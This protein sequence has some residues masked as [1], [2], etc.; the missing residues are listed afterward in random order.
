MF[1]MKIREQ[2]NIQDRTLLAGE[3]EYDHVPDNVII[4]GKKYTVLGLSL[5]VLPPMI[6]LE[7]E[8]TDDKLT[9]SVIS[10]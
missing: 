7:I 10:E 5:G 3:G 2:V 6:S 1:K 9:G 4:D 8:K